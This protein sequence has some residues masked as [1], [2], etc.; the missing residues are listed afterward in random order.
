MVCISIIVEGTPFGG[1]HRL[2]GL[3]LDHLALSLCLRR[4]V[5]EL[6]FFGKNEGKL[7]GACF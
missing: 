6:E 2:A 1:H 4:I 3:H 5:R 7:K